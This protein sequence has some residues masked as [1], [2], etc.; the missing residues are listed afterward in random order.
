[1]GVN[2]K[3]T[4]KRYI[5]HKCNSKR[6][7][8]SKNRR[9]SKSKKNT[10]RNY[11][12][13]YKIKKF[14]GGVSPILT[15]ASSKRGLPPPPSIEEEEDPSSKKE[16]KPKKI[17]VEFESTMPSLLPMSTSD[18][19]SGSMSKSSS[20]S[21]L[22]NRFKQTLCNT[23]PCDN[24]IKT[25][26]KY[27]DKN[28]V[29]VD[30][31]LDSIPKDIDLFKI[32]VFD[33]SKTSFQDF[34]KINDNKIHNFILFWN[35]VTKK[36]V[37]VTSEYNAIEFGSK[38]AM[39]VQR[40]TGRIPATFF[41]SGE[42][43]K[44]GTNITF[45]DTS[46]Q[47]HFEDIANIKPRTNSYKSTMMKWFVDEYIKKKGWDRGSSGLTEHQ[48][49][50]IKE[51]M[52]IETTLTDVSN[53]S[54]YDKV[55]RLLTT[56][57]EVKRLLSNYDTEK[58]SSLKNK[59]IKRDGKKNNI[60]KT[61]L[62]KVIKIFETKTKEELY[63]ISP[64]GTLYESY[65]KEI[66]SIMVE[67]FKK[68]FKSS[69]INISFVPSFRDYGVQKN[70]EVIR[71]ELCKVKDENGNNKYD[72]DLYKYDSTDKDKKIDNKDGKICKPPNITDS[73]WCPT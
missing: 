8:N 36:Y 48:L 45:H 34:N 50:E 1:M 15:R 38:H 73:K 7:C 11:T 40:L 33:E 23:Y 12:K 10:R 16:R 52:I 56:E 42:I 44:N 4:K 65:K 20:S 2:N 64:A 49:N 63:E 26:Q 9:N 19:S 28:F 67:A 57:G 54:N 58:N 14:R 13:K 21:P 46:S 55:K 69:I 51:A 47:Y 3:Y 30:Y 29:L 32:K 37:L 62:D 61:M 68:I 17:K 59:I 35:D 72:F 71:S 39:I 25:C 27:D 6:K 24:S 41:I 22:L 53:I 66:T 60:T 70:I 18:S 5:R 43:H 31:E